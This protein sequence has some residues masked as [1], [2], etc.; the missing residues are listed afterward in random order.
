MGMK[1]HPIVKNSSYAVRVGVKIYGTRLM[2]AIKA[3]SFFILI[4]FGAYFEI[5]AFI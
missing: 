1:V 2:T 5:L 4:V 3:F